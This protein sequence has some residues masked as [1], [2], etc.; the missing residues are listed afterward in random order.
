L[1]TIAGNLA[2]EQALLQSR[3]RSQRDADDPMVREQL[4]A[5]P[6][7][8]G[9][10]DTEMRVRRLH[11]ALHELPPKCQ[12]V[13]AMHYRHGMNY[14]QIGAQLEISANMVKKYVMYALAHCRRRMAGLR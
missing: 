5:A 10:L 12:A 3:N 13:V 9:Q 7:V 8:E 14:E 11:R 2:K 4:A 6:N 1:F